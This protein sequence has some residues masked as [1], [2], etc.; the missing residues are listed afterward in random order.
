MQVKEKIKSLLQHLNN[1]VYEKN[2]AIAL[3]LLSAVAGESIFLL[4]APGVAKSLIARRLK[5]A[6]KDG[7]TFEYLM[8]RFS[9][10]DEIFGPVSISKLKDEDKYERI[11]KNYL[12]D[13]DIVFLDE[14]WKAGPSIQNSLLT[15]INEKVF[16]NGEQEIKVPMKALIAASNEL[17]AQNE[18]LEALWDRFLVRL[19]IEGVQKQENFNAM[20]SENLDSYKDNVDN[21]LKIIKEEYEQWSAEI[22]KIEVPEN[23]FNVID[24]IRKKL[25]AHNNEEKNAENQIYISDRRWRK[26]VRLLRTSAFLNNRNA[27]DLMDCFL[28]KECLWNEEGQ[29]KI[30]ADF[31]S[32]AIQ[33]HGYKLQ[34][35]F[36]SLKEELAE[37]QEEIK[38]ETKF[39]KNT[40]IEVLDDTV[41]DHYEILK[42][43]DDRDFIRKIDYNR[44]NNSYQTISLYYSKTSTTNFQSFNKEIRKGNSKFTIITDDKEYRLKTTIKGEIRQVTKKPHKAV[45]EV[46]DKKVFQYLAVTNQQKEELEKYRTKDLA[47][48]RTNQFVNLA[49]ANIVEVHLTNT[50]K[51]IEKYEVEIRKIQND[52]KKLKDE[53]VIL[54][55][56]EDMK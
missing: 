5:Y 27:V 35:D 18:G 13:A 17:P 15:V 50:Q 29:R 26:I 16:R 39:E 54:I 44:L 33:K 30:V 47:H 45:E 49:L 31:V 37:F 24:V 52:Y 22:D 25:Q 19:V 40:R 23:V 36:K 21:S 34:F 6:F 32:D 42:L 53:E 51:E 12:P 8:S 43:D 3:S 9:T 56:K 11:V 55:E 2:E 46:W 48:L 4:G 41:K 10:P 20:I 7:K 14:I 28:I 38:E 1:G